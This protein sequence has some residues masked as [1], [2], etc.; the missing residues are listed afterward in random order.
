MTNSRYTEVFN[1]AA[2]LTE[3]ECA[4][5]WHFCAEWDGLLVGP[6]M[7]ELQH[8]TCKFEDDETAKAVAAAKEKTQ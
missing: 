5:G 4:Q 6:G 1:N 2:E 3:A 7:A 8:C